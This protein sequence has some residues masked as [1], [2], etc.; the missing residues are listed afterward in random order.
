MPTDRPKR[1]K[2]HQLPDNS[3]DVET[4]LK[5]SEAWRANDNVS[6]GRLDESLEDGIQAAQRWWPSCRDWPRDAWT[7]LFTLV[8]FGTIT[9]AQF[10]GAIVARSLALLGDCA[11]MLVDTL[12][13][14]ANL[15]AEIQVVNPNRERNQL[16]VSGV[17]ILILL[18]LSFFA[19]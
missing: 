18:V 12:T 15:K 2:F 13:Y 17:S 1:G 16:I 10:V 8:L 7:L 19:A 6:G 9:A 5:S 11:S 4:Q 3:V 14:A